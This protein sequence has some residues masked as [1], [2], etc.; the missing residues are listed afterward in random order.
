MQLNEALDTYNSLYIKAFFVSATL[1]LLYSVIN[2]IEMDKFIK[3]FNILDIAQTPR[4]RFI[5]SYVSGYF[6]FVLKVILSLVTLFILLLIIRIAVAALIFVFTAIKKKKQEG[7]ASAIA[8]ALKKAVMDKVE[9]AVTSNM[10][11]LLGFV[12]SKPFIIIFLVIV[13]IFLFFVT[14]AYSM[15]YNPEHI[16][17]VNN[18]ESGRIMWTHHGFMMILISS[19]VLIAFIYSVFLWFK[20][21]YKL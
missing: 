12:T 14:L 13:P 15:F 1:F 9:Q 8:D 2:L 5:Y 20:I 21:A 10:R 19:I 4:G 11:I 7:G 18:N 6:M 3:D 17:Q 16:Q